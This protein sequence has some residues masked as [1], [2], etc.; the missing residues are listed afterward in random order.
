MTLAGVHAASPGARVASDCPLSG[1]MMQPLACLERSSHPV[2][3]TLP[4][5]S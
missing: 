3:G 4:S 2:L 5:D 1:L